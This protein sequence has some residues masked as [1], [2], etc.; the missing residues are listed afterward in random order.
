M[1]EERLR[2]EKGE[3]CDAGSLLVWDAY[4]TEL[5][6]WLCP[7]SLAFILLFPS[8]MSLFVR[9]NSA[10]AEPRTAILLQP[11]PH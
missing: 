5:T 6:G 3:G 1:G 8:D 4:F 10:A 11:S 9:D 7:F 2:K